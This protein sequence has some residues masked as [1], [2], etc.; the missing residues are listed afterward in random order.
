MEGVQAIGHGPLVL[1]TASP[2]DPVVCSQWSV[3]RELPD[4]AL[5]A[6]RVDLFRQ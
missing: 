1:Y 5:N 2:H 6:E 3:A 4:A